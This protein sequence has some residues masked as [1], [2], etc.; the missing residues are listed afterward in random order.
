ML[1]EDRYYPAYPSTPEA[2]DWA[3][4]SWTTLK[5][6]GNV[7]SAVVTD[8]K[9][10]EGRFNANIVLDGA[11]IYLEPTCGDKWIEWG[12][13]KFQW[14]RSRYTATDDTLSLTWNIGNHSAVAKVFHRVDGPQTTT[15]S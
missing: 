7:L 4:T 12:E 15:G 13:L 14:I 11:R 8:H 9:G 5:V 1:T 2:K 10:G 6:T 3:G